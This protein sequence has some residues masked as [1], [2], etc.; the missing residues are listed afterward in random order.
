MQYDHRTVREAKPYAFDSVF[1]LLQV[2]SI[3][4]AGRR[5]IGVGLVGDPPIADHPWQNSCPNRISER[6]LKLEHMIRT[7]DCCKISR[8]G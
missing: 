5:G 6:V 1:L 7:R 4:P 8:R 3:E 2:D